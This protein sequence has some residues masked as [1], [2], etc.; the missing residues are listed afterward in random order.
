[1]NFTDHEVLSYALTGIIAAM[2]VVLWWLIREKDRKREE[3]LREQREAH[4]IRLKEQKDAF[5]AKFAAQDVFLKKLF[6]LHEIDSK[7]LF[8]LRLSIPE[9]HYR[10]GELD[11]RFDKMEQTNEKWFTKLFDRIESLSS[12]VKGNG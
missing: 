3:D 7:E 5:D 9:N 10:K 11:V 2:V 12:L 8:E 6:D 4:E 1:V